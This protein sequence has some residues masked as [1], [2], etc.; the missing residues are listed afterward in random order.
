MI[1][2]CQVVGLI[3]YHWWSHRNMLTADLVDWSQNMLNYVRTE[4]LLFK[5]HLYWFPINTQSLILVKKV[6]SFYL[7][8]DYQHWQFSIL[9]KNKE[10]NRFNSWFIWKFI[11][12]GGKKITAL[13]CSGQAVEI[14]YIVVFTE[15]SIVYVTNV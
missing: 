8:Q 10:S 7:Y 15:A 14:S 3:D 6:R 4:T 2:L 9:S 13:Q 5:G 12:S 11:S 1:L